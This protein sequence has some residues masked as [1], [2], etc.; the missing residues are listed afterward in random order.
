MN[1]IPSPRF[2]ACI[3]LIGWLLIA[4]ALAEYFAR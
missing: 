1:A 4:L 2:V 3:I